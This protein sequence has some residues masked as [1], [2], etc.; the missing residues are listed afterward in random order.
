M[1]SIGI[2][3]KKLI[4]HADK[5]IKSVGITNFLEFFCIEYS[6]ELVFVKTV[7]I[8]INE[9]TKTYINKIKR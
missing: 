1:N 7:M 6:T 2:M 5:L 9:Q 8:T 3:V 4:I